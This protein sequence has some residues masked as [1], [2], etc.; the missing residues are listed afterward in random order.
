MSGVSKV[1][2]TVFICGR[3]VAVLMVVILI[4]NAFLILV[5]GVDISNVVDTIMGPVRC[6]CLSVHG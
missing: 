2:E 5:M 4:V 6:D 1:L 3:A